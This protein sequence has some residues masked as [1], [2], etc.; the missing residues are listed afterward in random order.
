MQVISQPS[1]IA[2]HNY[3]TQSLFSWGTKH[4]PFLALQR[5]VSWLSRWPVSEAQR[6]SFTVVRPSLCC[7]YSALCNLRVEHLFAS[8]CPCK[9]FL[10]IVLFYT[11]FRSDY[12]RSCFS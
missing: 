3:F 5:K 11:R 9:L 8:L 4:L 2:F 1:T 6:S 7:P 12:Y 10:L